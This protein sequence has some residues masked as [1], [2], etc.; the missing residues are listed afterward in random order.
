MKVNDEDDTFWIKPGNQLK[1]FNECQELYEN[2]V[3]EVVDYE[4][5]IIG[6]TVWNTTIIGVLMVK[7]EDKN[8]LIVLGGF[9]CSVRAKQSLARCL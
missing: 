9:Q 3:N 8:R 2:R 1:L 5:G 4:P 7:R 6:F